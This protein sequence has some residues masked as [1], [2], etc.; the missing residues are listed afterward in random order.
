MAPRRH[1]AACPFILERDGAVLNRTRQNAGLHGYAMHGTWMGG[2]L[3]QTY[4][5]FVSSSTHSRPIHPSMYPSIM[6]WHPDKY[7]WCILVVED[8]HIHRLHSFVWCL[9]SLALRSV[10]LHNEKGRKRCR[11]YAPFE[12]ATLYFQTQ[13]SNQLPWLVHECILHALRLRLWH[14]L[15]TCPSACW[16]LIEM[17]K[18]Y[19]WYDDLLSPLNLGK[20]ESSFPVWTE[21]WALALSLNTAPLLLTFVTLPYHSP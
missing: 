21:W 2:W 4:P 1:C 6:E 18:L 3:I 5:V 12:S 15:G 9:S 19:S 16:V 10:Y 14:A 11:R 8:E 20:G 13:I 17:L 7:T